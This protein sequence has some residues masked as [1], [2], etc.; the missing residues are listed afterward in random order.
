M[1]GDTICR[2]GW[3]RRGEANRNLYVLM[4]ADGSVIAETWSQEDADGLRSLAAGRDDPPTCEPSMRAAAATVGLAV[5]EP[6]LEQ[7]ASRADL[8]LTLAGAGLPLTQPPIRHR[9]LLQGAAALIETP[10]WQRLREGQTALT[11]VSGDFEDERYDLAVSFAGVIGSAPA[12][13]LANVTD[14]GG[15]LGMIETTIQFDEGPDFL[16][17]ALEAA[18]AL[19][20]VPRI[21]VTDGPDAVVFLRR[22]GPALGA[23]LYVLADLDPDQGRRTVRLEDDAGPMLLRISA[24]FGLTDAED[25]FA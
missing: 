4:G 13:L 21:E 20:V 5:A 19:R 22:Y 17:A 10:S 16:T 1:P 24:G 3:A 25:I 6:T 15:T 11:S 9:M 2:V 14:F 7:E 12:K 23:V 8:A 18:Y